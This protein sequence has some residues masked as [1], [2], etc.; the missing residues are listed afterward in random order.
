MTFIDMPNEYYEMVCPYISKALNIVM[1]NKDDCENVGVLFKKNNYEVNVV[2]FDNGT[3]S[4]R[5]NV[6]GKNYYRK[7]KGSDW[8]GY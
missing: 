4:I 6:N 1:A 5:I 2:K 8:N 7:F 3:I